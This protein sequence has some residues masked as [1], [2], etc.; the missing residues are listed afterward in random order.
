MTSTT[1]DAAVAGPVIRVTQPRVV[2]SEWIKLRSLR[3]TVYTLIAT[4]VMTV[5]TGTL[6]AALVPA[7]AHSDPLMLSLRGVYLAQLTIGVLGVLL[8]TGEYS[9]GMI[10]ATISAAPRR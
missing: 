4:V 1:V 5:G 2:R 8:I 10:R 6:F 3:S 9:T 7:N